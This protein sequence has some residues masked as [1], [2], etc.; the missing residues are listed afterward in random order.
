MD[1]QSAVRAFIAKALAVEGRASRSEFWYAVLFQV[2]VSLAVQVLMGVPLLGFVIALVGGLVLIAMIIPGI[3]V[4]VRRLH[5][6]GRS[7]WWLLLVFVPVIGTLILLYW[8]VQRARPAEPVRRGP[9]GR[10]A[11]SAACDIKTSCAGWSFA[12]Q[13]SLDKIRHA[14]G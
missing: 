14:S 10:D 8:A 7:G 4:G 9:A 5:D 3:T 13:R 11:Y 1:F 2:L 6:I 12:L